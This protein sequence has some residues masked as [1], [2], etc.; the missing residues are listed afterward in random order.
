MLFSVYEEYCQMILN[1]NGKQS[2]QFPVTSIHM[3]TTY[4]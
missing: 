4:D 1:E 3:N 2:I